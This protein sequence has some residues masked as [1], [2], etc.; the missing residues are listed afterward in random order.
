MVEG[1]KDKRKSL[2][3]EKH[4]RRKQQISR[5]SEGVDLGRLVD[6]ARNC[7]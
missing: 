1:S 4:R 5:G 7:S 3:F 2:E 6:W